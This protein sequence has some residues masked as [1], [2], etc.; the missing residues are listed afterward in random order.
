[1]RARHFLPLGLCVAVLISGCATQRPQALPTVGSVDIQ[2]YA[3]AWYEIALL[4]N[5]FQSQC[6]ADTQANYSLE[7]S[8][9]HVV[10]R[11]RLADD[12]IDG[13]KGIATPVAGSNNSKLRV[14]FFRP[15]Y[16]NYW[17]LA[18]GQDYEWA[19]VGEPTRRYSWI[20]SRTP[21]LPTAAFKQ[22]LERAEALGFDRSAYS[23]TPQ[24][25]PLP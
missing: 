25:K 5:S 21:Q 7:G 23:F 16:G 13:A 3:G 14:S 10:N 12:S 2:R 19:L 24:T 1:M 4:P 9:I 22:A 8:K 11:C 18:L 17:I 15:F 6:V 20:L